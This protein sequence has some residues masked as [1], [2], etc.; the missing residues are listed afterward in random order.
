MTARL[1]RRRIFSVTMGHGDVYSSSSEFVL[2]LV[3]GTVLVLAL[4]H[5][6]SRRRPAD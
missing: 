3:P 6:A 2:L 4:L 1:Q 5:A